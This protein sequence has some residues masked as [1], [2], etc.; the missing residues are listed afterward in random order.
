MGRMDV[1]LEPVH[2][3]TEYFDHPVG[4]G[5][6]R[7]RFSWWVNDN[8]S[9]ARQTAYQ[10]IVGKQAGSSELWDSGKVQSDRSVFVTYEG[11]PLTSRSIGWW[12]VRT[13]D[14]QGCESPWSAHA[15]F[16]IGLLEPSD[17][18]AQWIGSSVVGGP[19]SSAPCPY[20]RRT[21]TLEKSILRARLYITALGLYECHINGKAVSSDVFRPGWTD[22][23]KR[24]QYQ[25]YD[26]TSFLHPGQNAIGAIL[27][28]GWYCGFIGGN[29]FGRQWRGDRPKLLVQ[30]EV[31]YS[32]GSR[33]VIISD[34][35]W[36]TTIGPILE[37]DLLMGEI[38]DARLELG[39][40]SCPAYED[41]DWNAVCIF[42]DPKIA[43]DAQRGPSVKA[44]ETLTYKKILEGKPTW[45]YPTVKIIDFGQNL[46]G[47]IRLTIPPG[48]NAS[49]HTIRIRYAEM[50]NKD[51]TLYTENLRNAKQ[52]DY[53]TPP[54]HSAGC[55]WESRFTFHGFRYME[56][57]NFPGELTADHVQA[58]A[59]YSEMEK[60]GSF[61]CS[62]SL[63]N[64]LQNNIEWGQKGNFI[65]VPTDCPQRDER[66]GWTGDA[67]VFIRTACFNRDVSGFFAKWLEDMIYSQSSEGAIPGVV[68]NALRPGD[69][70][71]G[72]PAWADAMVICPW[73][74]LR[75]YDDVG[76][77][78]RLYPSMQKFMTYL[79]TI[80][81]RDH[82]RAFD[83]C[84]FQGF[85]D[86]LAT[87]AENG[88][89][90][91]RTPTDLVG[92]AF[93]AYVSRQMSQ[94]A[95]RLG[96]IS[97]AE[98]YETLFQVIRQAF[99]N[100]FVT[101]AGL[102]AGHTQTAYVLALVFDLL[103]SEHR[104]IAIE[105]LVK[106]IKKHE[107]HLA[108]GFIG[109][110]HLLFAL[111]DNGYADIALKLLTQKTYPSWLYPVLNGAT[112]IWERWDGWSS[113]KGFQ[114]PDMNSFNHYAYG[115]VG[116]W[117]YS[118]LA[119][120]DTDSPGYKHLVIRPIP[121][122]GV[123]IT[124]AKATLVTPYG[125]ASSGWKIQD[126]QMII[127]VVVPPNTTATLYLA[128]RQPEHVEA[129]TH[130]RI[131]EFHRSGE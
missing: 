103:S 46:V 30:L 74:L 25:T 17:W 21:F 67:Q 104:K 5:E 24:V 64:Q 4:L 43:I 94:M 111:S 54:D 127:D 60:T 75:C 33:S 19:K 53:F 47:R 102:I 114:D 49:G 38:Y 123:G 50:L 108:T 115:A 35:K 77:I 71:N 72:G 1:L 106:N 22:Y 131:V 80:D 15:S 100:R 52:T 110:P 51:G 45:S 2:L 89:A 63:L 92:T 69:L 126:G 40:W 14:A 82:I 29:L 28:D 125:I 3:R 121:A 62:D 61:E 122:D 91:G 117:I 109:T 66:L 90:S 70:V 85:G 98:R 36:K 31:L 101:A 129:G 83:G 20:F 7:P 96:K 27:G 116:Q 79:E 86:W 118:R 59:L 99:N 44:M 13:W 48:E 119:G 34:E 87:D 65:D 11:T 81:S 128:G 41:I 105:E 37:S 124:H 78:E 9:G 130:R 26:V 84:K 32:D 39:D 95:R 42:P 93:Y 6:A 73:T 58:V 56:I 55:T 10:I 8:R 16:E 76:L 97:D 12:Q 18:S 120:L 68:P 112:T 57:S 107:M 23:A 88:S 113:E